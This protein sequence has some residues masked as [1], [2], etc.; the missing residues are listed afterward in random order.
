MSVLIQTRGRGTEEKPTPFPATTAF[1]SR[2]VRDQVLFRRLWRYAVTSVVATVVS[3]ATLL[4]LYGA[5]VLGAATSA[6]VA[7]LAGTVPSYLMSRFWIW[8]EADRRRPVRQAVAYWV[9]SVVS[10]LAS[11]AATAA[12][13]ANAPKGQAAHL[14]VVATA[15]VGTYAFSWV[16][17]FVVYQKV[18]F[19]SSG[20]PDLD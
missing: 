17:K 7:N 16:A 15:Y 18:L 11:S 10:L 6:V 20:K 3:E 9:I 12:A 2:L 8:S 19:R 13:A 5:G 4:G 1:L 14:V